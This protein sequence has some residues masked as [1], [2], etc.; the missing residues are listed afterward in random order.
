MT[1]GVAEKND[2]GRHLEGVG[3]EPEKRM[4]ASL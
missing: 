3:E 2:T 1:L 4:C